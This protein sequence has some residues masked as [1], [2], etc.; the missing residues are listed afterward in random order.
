MARLMYGAVLRLMETCRLRVKDVD[1]E[2][3]QVA[4]RDRKRAKDSVALMPE[5]RL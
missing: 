4:V 5:S 1:L 2:R 3:G